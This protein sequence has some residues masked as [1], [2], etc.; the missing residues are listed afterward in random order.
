LR[1]SWELPLPR[2]IKANFDV[3]ILHGFS[4]AT[5]VFS[6]EYWKVLIACTS[7]LN[8]IELIEGE[9]YAILLVV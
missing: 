4:I 1:D 3:A 8:S 6:D 9:T 2:F 7:K 5:T